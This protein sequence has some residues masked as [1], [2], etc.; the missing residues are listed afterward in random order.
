LAR[1]LEFDRDKALV[2]A[3]QLFWRQGYTAT[4]MSQ[5][6]ETMEIGRSSFYAAFADKRSL[7][8]DCLD[9][10][11]AR[12]LDM[13]TRFRQ[14]YPPQAAIRE[15][16]IHTLIDVPARRAQRGC[17]MVNTILELA[18]VDDELSHRAAASLGRVETEFE[19][20]LAE[21]VAAG[22]LDTRQTPAELA[23]YL[24]MVNQGLRVASRKQ[25]PK[26]V[27]SAMVDTALVVVNPVAA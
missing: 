20:C 10:F 23:Q 16:F 2:A 18:D 3:M 5:L 22:E 13:L 12:T 26:Q 19:S 14:Q 1:P 4:S 6:L 9:L 21:A 27:L 15:F 8:I 11:T 7:F 24:M 25:T 17:L